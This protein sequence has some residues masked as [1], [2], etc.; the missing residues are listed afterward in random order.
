[1]SKKIYDFQIT[2]YITWALLSVL[3]KYPILT[4]LSNYNF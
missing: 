2:Q 1:M 3:V 4:K